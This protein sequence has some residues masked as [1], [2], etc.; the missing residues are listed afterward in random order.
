EAMLFYRKCL[1]GKLT[2]QTLGDS[3]MGRSMPPEMKTMILQASLVKDDL[4]L[5]GTDITAD[6]GLIKGNS[7]SMILQC[8]SEKEIKNC[9]NSLSAGGKAGHAPKQNSEG[10]FF[11]ELTDKYGNNWILYF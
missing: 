1:G 8:D 10:I 4:I 3:P 5:M 11:S 9:Y 2:F 6:Q 7:V